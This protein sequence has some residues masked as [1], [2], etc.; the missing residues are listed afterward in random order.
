MKI[1]K[2]IR[3]TL[4]INIVKTI[5]MILRFR[6]SVLI[7]TNTNIHLHKTSKILMDKKSLLRIGVEHSLKQKTVVDIYKNG[8]LAI[9]G[10]VS[11]NAGTKVLIGE[12]AILSIGN[13]SYINE[14]SRIQC[15]E[16]IEI[17]VCCAIAWEV[18]ILDTDEHFIISQSEPNGKSNKASIY[19]GNRVWI[20]CKSIILKGVSLGDGCIV[21]AGSVVTKSFPARSLIAGNPAKIIKADVEWEME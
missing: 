16:R 5:F 14:H 13:G 18:N 4:K 17:G 3:T 6:C 20:G 11:I 8:V 19:I 12:N 9:N 21:A 10:K 15:R 1:N 7:G 2:L